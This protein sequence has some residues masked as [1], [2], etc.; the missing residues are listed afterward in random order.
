MSDPLGQVQDGE[1]PGS[2]DHFLQAAWRPSSVHH[3]GISFADRKCHMVMGKP[4]GSYESVEN[5]PSPSPWICHQASEG[6]MPLYG[7]RVQ[8][9]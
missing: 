9:P 8:L 4:M 5:A 6:G 2:P 7:Y 1:A 3:G